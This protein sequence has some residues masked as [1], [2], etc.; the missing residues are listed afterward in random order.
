MESSV[1]SIEPITALNTF[2][3]KAVRFRALQDA[4]HA[5]G[6]TYAE[7]PQLTDS[8]RI[9]RV[10][11]WNGESGAGFSRWIGILCAASLAHFSMNMIRR[12]ATSSPW[13]WL[14]RR[15]HGVSVVYW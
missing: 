14:R 6:S 9:K 2:L 4:P 11:R 7:E 8:D 13:C 5:F 10:E 1:I 3:F 12:G 15:V